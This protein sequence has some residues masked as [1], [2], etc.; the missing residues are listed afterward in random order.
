[1][2]PE[3]KVQKHFASE[4]PDW[5]SFEKSLGSKQFRAAVVAA[6]QSD[7]KLKKYVQNFGGFKAS[8][9]V[10]GKVKGSSGKTYQVKRLASGRLGCSCKDWQFIHSVKGG[11]C[12]HIK[13]L[14]GQKV[15]V[16]L[17]LNTAPLTMGATMA[18]KAMN[19][20]DKGRESRKKMLSA[21]KDFTGTTSSPGLGIFPL[22]G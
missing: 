21:R 11:D 1:M 9:D 8:K 16:A 20:R 12:K 3:E 13:Q 2:R 4:K 10:I 19:R 6:E 7:P 17:V 15:K 14:R 22:L 18:N 5:K